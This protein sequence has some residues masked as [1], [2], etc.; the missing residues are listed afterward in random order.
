MGKTTEESIRLT[1]DAGPAQ[2]DEEERGLVIEAMSLL[3]GFAG[4]LLGSLAVSAQISNVL[5]C[6]FVIVLGPAF[7]VG[8]L[9]R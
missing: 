4:T 6:L 8:L 3:K 7:V 5:V 2:E 9:G 1:P